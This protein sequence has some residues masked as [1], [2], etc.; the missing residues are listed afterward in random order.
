[1]PAPRTGSRSTRAAPV[2]VEKKPVTTKE[3]PKKIEKV[4]AAKTVAVPTPKKEA[5]KKKPATTVAEKKPVE[6]RTTRHTSVEK[7]KTETKV[8][9]V[10]NSKSVS[11]DLNKETAIVKPVI[12]T[13]AAS[14]PAPVAPVKVEKS[15]PA[16]AKKPAAKVEP[17][18]SR[19]K[20]KVSETPAKVE[21]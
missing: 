17:R 15:A 21:P 16:Q 7:S 14:T 12:A 4:V 18:S 11:K 10:T 13:P 20:S 1:M 6:P 5:D 9:T 3:T 19:S 8:A 2:V